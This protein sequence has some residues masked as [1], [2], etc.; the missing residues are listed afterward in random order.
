M[1]ASYNVYEPRSAVL[2]RVSFDGFGA[3]LGRSHH[4]GRAVFA[5]R[6]DCHRIFVTLDGGTRATIAQADGEPE[7]RRPDRPGVVTVV[8]AG[9]ER[10]VLLEDVD[11]LVLD[12]S[13]TD[14]FV[15]RCLDD[16]PDGSGRDLAIL[17]NGRSDRLSRAGHSLAAASLAGAP[18]LTLEGLAR[19]MVRHA[20]PPSGRGRGGGLD[21]I[22][23]ARV[24]ELMQDRLAEELTLSELAA[25]A[26]LGVSAFSRAFA[27]SLGTTPGRW[28][29]GLRLERARELVAE[30]S[31]PLV[32]IAAAAGYSDQ[33]HLT[34]AFTRRFGM[35]PGRWRN[36]N[37]SQP[38]FVPI[39]RKTTP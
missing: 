26:G 28:L 23:L 29:S 10:S 25:E 22:A 15:R 35:P 1:S 31:L 24:L 11:F 6:Q 16:E 33:A 12:V 17:Q 5:H 37:G 38:R 3:V 32:E 21:P 39:S 20:A 7:V 4:S 30:S 34:A 19:A 8:P 14:A 2:A 36:E 27:K 9:V 18:V 13:I